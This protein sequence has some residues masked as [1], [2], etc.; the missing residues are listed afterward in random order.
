[1]RPPTRLAGSASE[2]PGGGMRLG[3]AHEKTQLVGLG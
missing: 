3:G 2:T 1:V